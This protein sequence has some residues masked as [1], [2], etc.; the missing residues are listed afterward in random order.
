MATM[1]ATVSKRISLGG[2]NYLY[3]GRFTPDTSYS[4]G[5]NTIT[6]PAAPAVTLPEKIEYIGIEASNTGYVGVYNRTGA[7]AGKIQ[8]YEGAAGALKEVA[9]AANLSTSTFDYICIGA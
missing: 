3:L 9:A 7:N 6:S 2:T 1:T 5:G 8:L 4:T